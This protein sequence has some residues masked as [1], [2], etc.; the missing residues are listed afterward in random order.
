MHIQS[1]LCISSSIL[2][3]EKNKLDE[4]W[5]IPV[6]ETHLVKYNFN[7][8]HLLIIEVYNRFLYNGV[9]IETYKQ[10]KLLEVT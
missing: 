9:M 10:V 8:I 2:I 6:S 7:S 5:F 3:P 1:V 4:T